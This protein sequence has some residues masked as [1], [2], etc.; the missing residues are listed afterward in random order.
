MAFLLLTGWLVL[1][2]LSFLAEPFYLK[3]PIRP[4]RT[5][6]VADLLIAVGVTV[7]SWHAARFSRVLP[8]FF[9]FGCLAGALVV[10]SHQPS[11]W[12][13]RTMDL[14]ITPLVGYGVYW[15]GIIVLLGMAS[16]LVAHARHVRMDRSTPANTCVKC[17]YLLYGLP[18]PRCPECGEPF[19]PAN[20]PSS[21]PSSRDEIK[22]TS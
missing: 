22:E 2:I 20:V 11:W 15:F 1:I 13:L 8:L 7:G 9:I 4:D 12:V 3:S 10:L 17:G 18:E 19:E 16:R 21:V 14:G 5:N 6:V